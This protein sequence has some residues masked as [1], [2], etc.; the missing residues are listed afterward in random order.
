MREEGAVHFESPLSRPW[1]LQLLVG[2][3]KWHRLCEQLP[4]ELWQNSV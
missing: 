2:P 4:N 3:G 1:H